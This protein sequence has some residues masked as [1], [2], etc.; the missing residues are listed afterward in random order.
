MNKSTATMSVLLAT[1]MMAIGTQASAWERTFAIDA[2]APASFYAGRPGTTDDKA[3]D[4]PH[5]VAPVRDLERA[6]KFTPWRTDAERKTMLVAENGD[7]DSADAVRMPVPQAGARGG[8]DNA[9]ADGGNPAVRY[10]APANPRTSLYYRGFAPDVNTVYN[11]MGA[12]DAGMFEVSGTTAYGFDLDDNPATGGFVSPEGV[13]GID[14]SYYRALGCTYQN[15][16]SRGVAYEVQFSN[17]HMRDG[18]QTIVMR[19]TG[20]K[21]AMND[22][23]VTVEI[24]YSPDKLVKDARSNVTP[25][26][27]FRIDVNDPRYSK[28]KAKI[29]NG[30]LVARDLKTLKIPEFAYMDTLT[31]DPLKLSNARIQI[32]LTPD[33]K[34]EGLIGGYRYWADYYAKDAWNIPLID[35][36]GR[37][38]FFHTDLIAEYYALQ[39]NADGLPDPKTGRMTGISAA[40]EFTAVPAVVLVSDKPVGY[41]YPQMDLAARRDK[42]LFLSVVASGKIRRDSDPEVAKALLEGRN[43][44]SSTPPAKVAETG[45]DKP[46][47][48]PEKSAD[49]AVKPRD[50]ASR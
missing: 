18:L 42:S 2:F 3:A 38:N 29:V 44:G 15:R 32:K 37:E 5:G 47:P 36:P 31:V 33:G 10:R 25:N 7:L 34:A 28:F 4:C 6:L 26:Y 1:S 22:D 14:N 23:D 45:A 16:G 30:E 21:D 13:A 35:G 17:D 46:A 40:Y 27:S 43:V 49:A 50:V 48:A 9:A 8:G 11:P 19:I 39:R 12:V 20:A 24:G 41:K